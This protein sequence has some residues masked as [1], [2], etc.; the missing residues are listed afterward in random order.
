MNSRNWVRLFL[1]TLF[2]GAISTSV[3]GFAV[4]WNEYKELFITFDFLEI[5]S[6]L[7]WLVGVGFIFSIISQMGFFAYL[8]VHRFGLGIFRSL[9][10]PVQLVLIA[11]VFFDLVY[12]RYQA[13]AKEGDLLLP[14]IVLA[15][16]LF[17]FSLIIAYIKQKQTNKHAF[18]PA[19]F[20]MFVITSIEWF[21]ALRVNEESW[22]Y[23]M[24]IP[25]LVC[26]AYQLLL[27]SKISKNTNVKS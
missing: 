19:L 16:I 25:L 27:L 3:V 21:P 22:L 4:K 6:I 10:K 13:F 14:Y 1:S 15:F 17:L 9:W 2:V 5:L 8:T 24:L 12:F 7:L 18:I 11:F 26:N 20:F 23:L